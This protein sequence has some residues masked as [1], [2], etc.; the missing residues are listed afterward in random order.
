MKVVMQD[1]GKLCALQSNPA[2]AHSHIYIKYNGELS[3][4][5]NS[6]L[7]QYSAWDGHADVTGGETWMG[8]RRLRASCVYY[9]LIVH[10]H[11]KSTGH[12]Q[13]TEIPMLAKQSIIYRL[14]KKKCTEDAGCDQVSCWPIET[15]ANE[16]RW[17]GILQ[18]HQHAERYW[19]SLMERKTFICSEGH[20]LWF[21]WYMHT[22][23]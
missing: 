13:N 7:G 8:P 12:F 14:K 18:W 5:G 19:F 17:R 11:R 9:S 15:H 22:V 23:S 6:S 21:V 3:K 10:S 4:D 20:L 1:S 16:T 2:N